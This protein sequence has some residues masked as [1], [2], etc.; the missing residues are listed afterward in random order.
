MS[1]LLDTNVISEVRKPVQ[2]AGVQ[3]WFAG[4]RAEEL[5]LSVMVAG[6]I[7]R[8]IERLRRRDPAQ[9]SVYETWLGTLRRDYVDRILPVTAEIAEEWGRL[10]DVDPLPVIDGLLAATAR[11]HGLILVT[12][13]T[14]DFARTGVRLL[15][16]FTST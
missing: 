14:D 9:A 6:E 7:R 16:P 10:N 2:N 12:R 5:F 11:V 4:V 15:N 13:N 3:Q 8:G 1:C